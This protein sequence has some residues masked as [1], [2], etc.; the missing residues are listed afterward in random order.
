MH[1]KVIFKTNTG[2]LLE[3][4][5]KP[6]LDI[7]D[8]IRLEKKEYANVAADDITFD[9]SCPVNGD[10]L[11]VKLTEDQARASEYFKGKTTI[12]VTV[13]EESFYMFVDLNV[14]EYWRSE[15]FPLIKLF[16]TG[17]FG[18]T[19]DTHINSLSVEY[20][21]DKEALISAW[22]DAGCPIEWDPRACK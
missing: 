20:K 9:E 16:G 17:F 18:K 7:L 11:S 8:V 3:S 5:G 4:L 12:K 6:G 14:R 13:P 21:F 22:I 19:R 1:F 15:Y 10:S 2:K